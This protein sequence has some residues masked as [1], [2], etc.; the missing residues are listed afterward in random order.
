MNDIAALVGGDTVNIP[1]RPGEARETLANIERANN[2]IGWKPTISIE[3][4]FSSTSQR[5]I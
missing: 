2:M 3:D 1:E 5:S 4:D